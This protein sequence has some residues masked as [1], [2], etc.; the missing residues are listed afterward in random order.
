MADET[1][2]SRQ[3]EYTAVSTPFACFCAHYDNIEGTD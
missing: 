1:A 3:Y 2:K